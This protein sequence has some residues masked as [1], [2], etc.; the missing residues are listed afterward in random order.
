MK[1][2]MCLMGLN[3]GGAETHVVELCRALAAQGVDVSVASSGGVYVDEL[4]ACGIKHFDVPLHNKHPKN[5]VKSYFILKKIIRGNRF[6]VVHAHARIPAYVCAKLRRRLAFSFV[7]TAHWIFNPSFPWN[8]LTKWGEHTLAVSEDIRQYLIENYKLQSENISVT[9][10]GIDDKKFSRDVDFSDIAKEFGF[11]DTRNRIVCISRMDTDRS[12]AALRLIE[13]AHT[14][15]RDFDDL[16]IVIV[17]GGNDFENIQ[18]SANEMNE[19]IGRRAIIIT[20]SRTDINKFISAATVFVGVSRAALE[21]MAAGVPTILA[22]NEGYIG[23]FDEST[24][25]AAV[26]TNLCCRGQ[27]ETTSDKLERD[28]RELLSANKEELQKL[29]EFGKITVANN[30]S[31]E[32][33]ANDAMTIYKQSIAANRPS[34]CLISGYYGYGNS[35]DDALLKAMISNLRDLKSDIS[36]KVLSQNPAETAKIYGVN[37]VNR[38]DFHKISKILR[39][40]KLLISGGG[41]LIQDITSRK[42]LM[43]Y[44][45]VIKSALK[46]GSKVMLYAN[47]IGPIRYSKNRKKVADVLAKVDSI[48]LR[49]EHSRTVLEELGI[50]NVT[51]TADPVFYLEPETNVDHIMEDCGMGKPQSYCVISVRPW[52]TNDAEFET[53]M[54]TICGQAFYKHGIT[55]LFLPM[56]EMHD[57]P[58]CDAVQHLIDVL[59]RVVSY[60]ILP[61]N[62]STE[63][64][65]GV[66]AGAE[67]VIGMR[68]HTLIYAASAGVP[69]IGLVYDPKVSAFMDDMQQPYKQ[70]VENIDSCVVGRYIDEI[71]ESYYKIACKL[72]EVSEIAKEKAAITAKIAIELLES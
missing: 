35:G 39:Q 27:G 53:K 52:K 60:Q 30:Y 46:Q 45:W 28:I 19:K 25:D 8:V 10:N 61:K 36:I 24:L 57:K 54:A 15:C 4:K 6:D 58:L 56:Q 64:L 68:L 59:P 69:V 42:S 50:T 38:F 31:V 23:V 17:G 40:T 48:T 2:L 14:L 55:P 70:P 5:L 41:S 33:M 49:D 65:L 67:F 51:V 9:I 72:E 37:A 47:G 22:G 11:I 63:E 1:V 44:L 20:N 43:Y 12:L 3:I 21:A 34:D 32:R 66:I 71:V 29:S 18:R 26:E 62:L 7:T 13:C 16:E